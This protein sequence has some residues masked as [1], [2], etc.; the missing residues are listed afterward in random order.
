MPVRG[1]EAPCLR[2]ST[3]ANS[4]LYLSRSRLEM[5]QEDEDCATGAKSTSSME[6]PT[7]TTISGVPGLF[8]S[9]YVRILKQMCLG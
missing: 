4:Q 6:P 3:P 1:S 7:M 5:K 8:M 2:G 9:Q